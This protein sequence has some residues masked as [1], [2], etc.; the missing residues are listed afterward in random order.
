MRRGLL[1]T[2]V[3]AAAAGDRIAAVGDFEVIPIVGDTAVDPDRLATAEVAY[4]SADAYPE[5]T[6]H[7]MGTM[8]HAPSLRW[9]HTF[10]TGVDHP[11]F[12]MFLDKGVRL[13]SS[14]GANARPIAR[15]VMMHLLALSRR[16]P[17]L[18]DAQRDHRW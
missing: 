8:L 5:R 7:V 3:A 17:S 13:T 6:M 9:L 12:G 16:L 14:A 18:I 1:C 11:V 2:D 15:T 10:S 4:F